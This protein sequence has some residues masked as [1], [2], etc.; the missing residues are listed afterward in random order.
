MNLY[1]SAYRNYLPN[2]AFKIHVVEYG[3]R[4][5]HS[6]LGD[7]SCFQFGDFIIQLQ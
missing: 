1:D 7:F 3:H 4:F 6:A 2:I 5:I